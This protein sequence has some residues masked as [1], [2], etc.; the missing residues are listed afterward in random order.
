MKES[1]S[2]VTV[3]SLALGTPVI[4]TDCGGPREILEPNFTHEYSLPH[5]TKYGILIDESKKWNNDTIISQ[6]D[7]L[8]NNKKVL[9]QMSLES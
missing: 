2:I 1:F 3:E 9:Y 8:L 5:I 7:Y 6:I 4:S